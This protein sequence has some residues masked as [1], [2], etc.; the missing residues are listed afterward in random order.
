MRK[1]ALYCRVSSDDQKE[2]DTI[3]NQI[4][5]LN[6]FIELRENFKVFKE[7]LDNGV[8]G[9][10][11]FEE[12]PAGKELIYDASKKLFDTVLV[13]K[14]DRF[15][16]NTL[17]GLKAIEMLRKYDIEIMSVT[18]PF[19][20]NTATGRFQF[21]TYLNMAELERN[22]I[23]DRM[24]IGA[25]RAAKNGK[26]M[27]GI[28]PYGYI[29]NSDGYL[30]IN[31]KEANVIREIF[32]LYV[33]KKLSAVNIALYLN[34]LNIPSSCGTGKGKRT[35]NV[36]GLWRSGSILRILNSTTYK[37]VHEYGKR[38]SRRKE[39]I[40]RKVPAI[41]TEEIWNKAQK[42]KEKNTIMSKRNMKNREFLLRKLIKCKH[43][44]NTYYGISYKKKS[45]VYC[46]SG[47]RGENSRLLGMKCDNININ[48]EKIEEI[49]WNDC[50]Y[51][52][53]NFDSCV[54]EIKKQDK[55]PSEEA[56]AD[57]KKLKSSLAEIKNEKNNILTLFRKNLI[58]EED[59]EQQLK[60]I[61]K[62]EEK[63][64]KLIYTLEEKLNAYEHEDE[65]VNNMSSKIKIY[66]NKIDNLTF[67]DK[68]KI[69]NLLVKRIDV[70]T[71]VENGAK[72]SKIEPIYNLVKLDNY[73]DMDE[74][75]KFDITKEFIPIIYKNR[76][77]GTMLR[78]LRLKNN[79]TIKE[80]S[81]KI[82]IS[83]TTLMMV[84]KDKIQKPYYYWKLICNCF[85]TNH[86]EYLKLYSLREASIQ[87]KLIKVRA[88]LGA[89]S[90]SEVGDYL[91]YSE[92]F[93]ID[94]LTRYTPKV[95]HLE[96]INAAIE[97]LT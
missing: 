80:L 66:Y 10:I 42:Q 65:L 86:I 88:L 2:R 85:N 22:N 59:I 33:N 90:W 93:I 87:E 17:S 5:I 41:V 64:K 57:L 56:R 60:D 75:T 9:T 79:L 3:E 61:K 96:R 74:V 82:N 73:T 23:L 94:L 52:I 95:K 39:T 49:I 71:I 6:T 8:S 51:I 15:G 55:N 62:E 31:E 50:L 43:C 30:E 70:E 34:N 69:I 16:R 29:V 92:G 18:E 11:P 35:K 83:S 89:K 40:L 4:E 48:A 97:R 26:W 58:T 28:V 44:G 91:G 13:W 53:K 37:G 47:K 68:R 63:I 32:D 78:N 46:C 7:Y 67:E 36:T 54:Q 27:G 19:D 81:K 20:L 25:T 72:V 45:A 84:E 1:V 38:G 77:Y 12:R 21:I 76:S 24:Y 14:I